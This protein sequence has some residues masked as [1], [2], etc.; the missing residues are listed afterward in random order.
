MYRHVKWLVVF[1]QINLNDLMKYS[2]A[3]CMNL[4]IKYLNIL[5]LPFYLSVEFKIL[6]RMTLPWL[7]KFQCLSNRVWNFKS[8]SYL[9]NWF[10]LLAFDNFFNFFLLPH[11]NDRFRFKTPKISWNRLAFHKPLQK[12][13]FKP[14]AET[15]T[16][17]NDVEKNRQNPACQTNP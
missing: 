14:E 7:L 8:L 15:E 9:M 4:W 6:W 2:M 11:Q 12:S 5:S 16:I 10:N 17:T 13:V 1:F 3:S